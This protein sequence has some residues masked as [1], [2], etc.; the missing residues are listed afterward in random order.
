MFFKIVWCMDR[1]MSV[2]NA[3]HIQQ[4][5]LLTSES[6]CPAS[7]GTSAHNSPGGHHKKPIRLRNVASKAESF[8]TLHIR[9]CE[10]SYCH[11][12]IDKGY[13]LINI[14]NTYIGLL[15]S[16]NSYLWEKALKKR[17]HVSY[18]M[19]LDFNT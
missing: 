7:A 1:I 19:N 15:R 8:D 16:I 17:Q 10:V 5:A 3:K 2:I 6:F 11:I 18:K 14:L 12:I 9:P 13:E 4:A